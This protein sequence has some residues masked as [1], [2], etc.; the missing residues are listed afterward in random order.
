MIKPAAIQRYEWAHDKAFPPRGESNYII[1]HYILREYLDVKT[2]LR[3]MEPGLHNV[4]V[5]VT[6][7]SANIALLDTSR[8]LDSDITVR[9]GGTR[10]DI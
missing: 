10:Y 3:A 2:A 6:A 4:T 9:A 1:P 8:L 5:T 7:T